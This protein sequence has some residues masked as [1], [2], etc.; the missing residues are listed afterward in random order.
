MKSKLFVTIVALASLAINTP[1]SGNISS[2]LAK[3]YKAYCDSN[4]YNCLKLNMLMEVRKIGKH[5]FYPLTEELWL[6]QTNTTNVADDEKSRNF[7]KQ[8][9]VNKDNI[10]L[11]KLISELSDVFKTHSLFFNVIP[12]KDLEI[13]RNGRDGKF[14]LKLQGDSTSNFVAHRPNTKFGGIY[15]QITTFF[16]FLLAFSN[17]WHHA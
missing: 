11:N 1:V 16:A 12:G 8:L 4:L 15:A 3:K 7:V 13:Y 17:F 6:E 10:K 9:K 14:N 2:D 5:K